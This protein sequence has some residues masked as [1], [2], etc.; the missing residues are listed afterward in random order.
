MSSIY[1]FF[2][3]S[4]GPVCS[5]VVDGEIICCIEEERMTR[6]KS[7]DNYD[8]FPDLSSSAIEK[9]TN[10]K[11]TDSDFCVFANP[12]PDEYARKITNNNYETVSH[13]EAHCYGSY[14]TSGMEGKVISLSYDGGGDF[15][16]MKIYLCEDGK[17]TLVRDFKLAEYGSLSHLWGFSTSGIMGYS[18]NGEGVWKMCKDEGK[19]MG[20]APNGYYDETIYNMLNTCINYSDLKFF[21]SGT[22][23]KTKFLIDSMFNLGYFNTQRKREIFSF[24]LQLLTENL[25]I[26]FIEDL[27][28]LY[29]EY[30]KLCLSGGLFANVKLNQ[31]INELNWVD[32]I[33]IFPAMG[34]EGLSLGGCI[35]KS[36]ELGE[37]VKPKALNNAY[38]GLKYNNETIFEISKNYNFKK[39]KYNSKEIAKDLSDGKIIGWFRDGFEYGPRSLGARSILVRPTDIGAH[40]LLNQRLKRHEIMPFAPIIMD[41]YFNEVFTCT[42]SKYAAE[43]MTICYSTKDNW[44]DKIPAVIQK[45]DKTARP[46]NVKKE[47]LPEFWE[48]LNEYYQISGIP[49]LLNTSFNSHNEPIIDNPKQAFDKL[50]EGIIDKLVIEDYV[51]TN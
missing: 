29:P 45:S 22:K 41:E 5:L 3:A 44:I 12:T 49:L 10:I 19:L 20:M 14:F 9:F 40:Q 21:P 32:E 37:W 30:T 48:I 2:G 7:G 6:I 28:K 50:N 26:N 39:T 34:D 23:E 4:H 36:V 15:S 27:H 46:Q 1:G 11:I 8:V 13:H 31:K 17:M 33:Y 38:F 18:P 24:N 16:V 25:F 35:K 43:F 51:Y 42:K 47:K